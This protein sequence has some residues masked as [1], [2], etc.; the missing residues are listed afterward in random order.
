MT[1]SLNNVLSAAGVFVEM[2]VPI[3]WWRDYDAGWGAPTL[4]EP[5]NLPIPFTGCHGL[6]QSST[7]PPDPFD[8]ALWLTFGKDSSGNDTVIFQWRFD[9]YWRFGEPVQRGKKDRYPQEVLEIFEL[10]SD[11]MVWEDDGTVSGPFTVTLFTKTGAEGITHFWDLV[12]AS[13]LSFN[14]SITPR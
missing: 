11:A 3:D 7:E 1:G 2:M 8:G 12:G 4:D 10:R 13:Y 5:N 9:Y 14:L 6:S